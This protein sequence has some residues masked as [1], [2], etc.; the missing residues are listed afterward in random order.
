MIDQSLLSII[1]TLAALPKDAP[2]TPALRSGNDQQPAGTI[3][4]A[5]QS[6]A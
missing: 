1:T 6:P 2:H 5:Y 3:H 4:T